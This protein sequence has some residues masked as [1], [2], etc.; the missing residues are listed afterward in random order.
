MAHD[1]YARQLDVR[2]GKTAAD[3]HP[4][5]VFE[6]KVVSV[7]ELRKSL[8]RLCGAVDGQRGADLL[9]Q[10]RRASRRRFSR[11]STSPR[12]LAIRLATT[13][14]RTALPIQGPPGSGKTYIGAQ[15][16]RAW[17]RRAAR[18]A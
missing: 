14:D 2:K 8:L 9:F 10:R 7:D 6:A 17:W 5:S 16:I 15:M 12:R 18:W 13:L 1:R 11:W 3:V 4:S